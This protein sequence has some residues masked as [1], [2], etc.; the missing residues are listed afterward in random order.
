MLQVKDADS[1]KKAKENLNKV[2]ANLGLIANRLKELPVPSAAERGK[3]SKKMEEEDRAVG[4]VRMPV[5][6]AHMEAMPAELK[7][8]LQ[9]ALASFYKTVDTHQKV[10]KAY[11][12]PDPQ[13]AESEPN[14]K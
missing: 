7:Q 12:E 4:N 11:F 14:P 10:F 1:L 5:L 13:P 3:L 8:G 6:K 2:A 9:S